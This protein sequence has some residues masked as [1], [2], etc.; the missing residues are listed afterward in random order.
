MK[1]LTQL[2]VILLVMG[3]SFLAG[4]FYRSNSTNS[5]GTGN[6]IG[7]S[8]Y[9]W[10]GSSETRKIS[11]YFLAPRDLRMEV[12]TNAT[13]D[14][15]ILDVEGMHLWSSDATLKPIYSFMGIQQEIFKLQISRRG[16]YGFLIYNPTNASAVYEINVALHGYEKDLLWVSAGFTLVGLVIISISL[17]VLRRP[18]EK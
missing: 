12:K 1:R 6:P 11:H 10:S 9:T 2:G 14:L 13:V 8:Q 15:Y 17:I 7:L 4:T 18:S 5:F 3:L 16:E